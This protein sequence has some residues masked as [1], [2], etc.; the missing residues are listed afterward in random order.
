M[1]KVAIYARVS[2]HSNA[3]N[4]AK[5]QSMRVRCF[6][7]A[8]GY[9][10][11]EA[12]TVIGDRK[13]AYGQLMKLLNSA[14]EKGIDT[15]VM[16]STNRI[17]GTVDEM[18]EIA[19]AFKEAGVSIEAIDGSHEASFNTAMLVADF[20]AKAGA[21]AEKEMMDEDRE[22]VFGYDLID[23]GLTVNEAEAEVVKYIFA[24]RLELV[25]NPPAELIQ[26]VIDEYARHG[27]TLTVEEAKSK[28][29]ESKIT[30]LIE[31]EVAEKWPNEYESMLQKQAHNHAL[32]VRKMTRNH[33]NTSVVSSEH[34]PIVS[35]EMWDKLQARIAEDQDGD[36]QGIT[37]HTLQ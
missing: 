34:E 10:V 28:I 4:A 31:D 24:R 14:K 32:Y 21:Q 25:S 12:T 20:L 8:Q 13:M 26:G 1:K 6:C 29:P 30:K 22:L 16:A 2:N 33:D 37:I 9:S 18:T 17:A 3:E 35:T 23:N 36:G 5:N 27:E 15:I 7:E 19:K 11:E